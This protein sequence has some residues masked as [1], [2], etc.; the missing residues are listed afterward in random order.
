MNVK[1]IISTFL[2]VTLVLVFSTLPTIAADE[3]VLTVRVFDGKTPVKGLAQED[4]KLEING[5]ETAL[6][7]FAEKYH[8]ID[9]P[10]SRKSE[11]RLFV[12]VFNISDYNPGLSGQVEYLFKEV[13]KPGDRMMVFTNNYFLNDRPTKNVKKARKKLER[14]LAMESSMVR[15]QL[16]HIETEMKTLIEDTLQNNGS[17]MAVMQS[18]K[19]R[20]MNLFEQFKQRSNNVVTA[21]GNQMAEFLK[22]RELPKWVLHFHQVGMFPQL[23]AS[24]DRRGKGGKS[25]RA[26]FEQWSQQYAWVRSDLAA[27]DT[28]LASVDDDLVNKFSQYF[29]NSD[30]G[31]HAFIMQGTSVFSPEYFDFKPVSSSSE[32]LVRRVAGTGGNDKNRLLNKENAFYV[33]SYAPLKK[34]KKKTSIKVSLKGD[35]APG[36]TYRLVYDRQQR[37]WHLKKKQ[38][39]KKPGKDSQIA[40][41]GVSYIK[42]IMSVSLEDISMGTLDGEKSGKIHLKITILDDKAAQQNNVEKAFKCKKSSFKMRMKPP[43][44]KKG[45]YQIVVQVRD[46]ITGKNDIAIKD[47][48]IR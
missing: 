46:L 9:A 4:F 43:G 38:A 10:S 18:F 26:L 6:T 39:G 2:A 3:A 8:K 47:I 22:N 28:G 14:I 36:K 25:L 37:P 32:S 7:G 29:L 44:L 1:T 23:K 17:P 34:L 24:W 19:S 13:I 21:Q 27:L 15:R 20:Y 31:F 42:G 48:R 11:P 33:L 45:N 35:S 5:K 41:S 40:V 30:A 12:L 16:G